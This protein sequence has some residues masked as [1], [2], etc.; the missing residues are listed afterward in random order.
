[1][2]ATSITSQNWKKKKKKL[3]NLFFPNVSSTNF[4]IVL[5][6]FA[7]VLILKNE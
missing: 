6:K 2:I 1:M 5:L 4:A 7:Q 3:L